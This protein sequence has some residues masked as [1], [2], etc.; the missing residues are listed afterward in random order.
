MNLL[1]RKKLVNELVKELRSSSVRSGD[2]DWYIGFK[3]DTPVE[4]TERDPKTGKIVNNTKVG[5]F[6]S[7]LNQWDADNTGYV[8]EM[9]VAADHER[10]SG[11]YS[12]RLWKSLLNPLGSTKK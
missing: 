9:G 6:A 5:K 1:L 3:T 12:Y 11:S 7:Y 2:V 10:D 4:E 8:E